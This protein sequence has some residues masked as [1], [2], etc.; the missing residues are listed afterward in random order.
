MIKTGNAIFLDLGK[1]G[2]SWLE[3]VL[4]EVIDKQKAGPAGIRH[5][6]LDFLGQF[7]GA[8]LYTVVRNPFTYYVSHLTYSMKTNGPLWLT[9]CRG[10]GY[11]I[12]TVEQ[13]VEEMNVNRRPLPVHNH[14]NPEQAAWVNTPSDVGMLTMQYVL[15]ADRQFILSGPKTKK[16]IS[17]WYKDHWF[18]SANMK[19]IN[20][21]EL[22][23]QF[24]SLLYDN[25]DKFPLKENWEST[26]KGV[27]AAGVDDNVA[28]NQRLSYKSFHTE[29][30]K[31]IIEKSDDILIEHFGYT[32]EEI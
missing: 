11:R 22:Q 24:V 17:D 15:M 8:F 4:V 32:F 18:G 16:Q 1:C 27:L 6:G 7:P 19:A 26:L 31:A 2:T 12:T 29:K 13:Y 14:A 10:A 30:S 28:K 21:S 25:Q 9:V 23:E 5:K 3:A 20:N